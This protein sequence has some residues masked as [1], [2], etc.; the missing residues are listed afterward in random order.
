VENPQVTFTFRAARL[1][2][3][4]GLHVVSCFIDSRATTQTFVFLSH[5]L[6]REEETDRL[7]YPNGA[8]SAHEADVLSSLLG[9]RLYSYILRYKGI[10]PELPVP[11]GG[12]ASL[13]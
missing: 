6:G 5:E 7:E 2:G 8:L 9:N 13:P 12:G 10:Q 1:R 11:D 3:P 4:L